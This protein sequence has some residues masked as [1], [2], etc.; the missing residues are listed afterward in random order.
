METRRITADFLRQVPYFADLDDVALSDIARRIRR[1]DYAAGETIVVEGWP[2]AG[3]SLVLQG[4]VRLFRTAPD[5][6][7]QVLRVI[8][9]G[10]TFDD[11]ALFDEGPSAESAA[12]LGP[13]TVGLVPA[14]VFRGLLDR[15][16]LI[17]RAAARVLASRQRAL[18]Q[19]IEDLAL[20]DVTA[21]VAGLLL[22]CAGRRE[23][24]VDVNRHPKLTPYR[25]SILTPVA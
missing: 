2:C 15:H 13:A 14:S 25:R 5:G 16:P 11:A 19:V 8:G 22:G 18:G 4:H 10:R 24:M 1:R 3:L 6:R 9:P 20:R 7:E 23:H 17:A 12:A 21:R